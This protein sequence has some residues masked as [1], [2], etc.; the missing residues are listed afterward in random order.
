MVNIEQW[1]NT[2][3]HLLDMTYHGT[4][5]VEQLVVEYENYNELFDM[6]NYD[7]TFERVTFDYMWKEYSKLKDANGRYLEPR[8]VSELKNLHVPRILFDSLGVG[9]FIETCF[10]NCVVTYWEDEL[11]PV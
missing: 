7:P 11:P 1:Q 2:W 5:I 10:P 8:V 9:P 3:R 6:R 4:R